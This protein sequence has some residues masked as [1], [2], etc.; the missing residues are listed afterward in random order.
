MEE[1]PVGGEQEHGHLVDVRGGTV[2]P[3]DAAIVLDYIQGDQLNMAVCFR[4]IVKIDF[5]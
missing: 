4:Y 5:F 3:L 1:V 2:L